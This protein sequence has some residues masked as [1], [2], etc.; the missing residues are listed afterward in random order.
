M[1]SPRTTPLVLTVV[2]ADLVLKACLTTPAW[3]VHRQTY[4]WRVT[5]ALGLLIPAALLLYRP[6][7][8]G[9][10]LLL[11]GVLGNL[12]DSLGDG[13]VLNPF[14]LRWGDAVFAFNLADVSLIVGSMLVLCATPATVRD[15]LDLLRRRTAQ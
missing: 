12:I 9:G 3:A 11:A 8:L 7:A 13:A 4:D 14:V 1:S 15:L 10:A 2:A 5:A 6:T